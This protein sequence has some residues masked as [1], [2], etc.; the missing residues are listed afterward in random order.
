[1]SATGK[2]TTFTITL[3]RA[4]VRTDVAPARPAEPSR[5]AR[6]GRVLV[7]DDESTIGTVV[8]RMLTPEHDVVAVTRGT[9]ALDLVKKGERFD[10]ILCDLMMPEMGGQE[11]F[12]T[13]AKQSPDMAASVVFLTGGAFTPDAQAFLGRANRPRVEKPFDARQLREAVN[14]RV[15]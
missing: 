13:L 9:D 6:R 12:E 15:R 8:R 4:P 3:P 7:V 10:V 1:M 2:G 14:A 11:M 5:A